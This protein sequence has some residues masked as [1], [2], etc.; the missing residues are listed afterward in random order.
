[1]FDLGKILNNPQETI[2]EIILYGKFNIDKLSPFWFFNKGFIGKEESKKV[3]EKIYLAEQRR[4]FST[5]FIDVVILENSIELGVID[6]QN[7]DLLSDLVIGLI[8]SLESSINPRIDINLKLHFLAE[9]KKEKKQI[10]NSGLKNE[11]WSEI[12]D[13]SRGIYTKVER[14]IQGK[15][16]E[17]RNAI[18]ISECYRADLKF[19]YHI[20]VYNELNMAHGKEIMKVIDNELIFKYL[21]D[22]ILQTNMLTKLLMK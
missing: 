15:E 6:I 20:N 16:F 17:N 13:E 1:M 21:N 14:R 10:L 18:S 12:L 22:S 11:F 8:H 7:F 4:S 5:S 2:F 3:N 19:P 9:S